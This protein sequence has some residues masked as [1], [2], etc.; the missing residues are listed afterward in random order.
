MGGW[1]NN[2]VQE[3]DTEFW[4]SA[5]LG[6][7]QVEHLALQEAPVTDEGKHITEADV[8]EEAHELALLMGDVGNWCESTEENHFARD[9]CV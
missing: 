3:L 2:Q 1:P 6:C 5:D 8:C 7:Y 9:G 4:C